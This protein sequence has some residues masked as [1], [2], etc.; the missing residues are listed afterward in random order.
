V[1]EQLKEQL[2]ESLKGNLPAYEAHRKV[3]GH[4]KPIDT[5]GSIGK[6]ARKSAVLLLVY[7]KE[8]IL[9]TVFI[10]RPSYPGVHSGQVGLPGGKV[11]PEDRNLQHT[12]LREARE[13]LNIQH[14]KLEVLGS[15]SPLYVPPSNFLIHPYLAFQ[16]SRPDFIPDKREVA[17]ILECPL[18]QLMGE[19]KLV[20][21]KVNVNG[22]PMAVRGYQLQ[23]TIIW[24]ATGMIIKEFSEVLAQTTISSEL[25]YNREGKDQ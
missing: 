7:P 22:N 12:A 4:R 19:E 20:S 8:E 13:E 17:S 14:E 21:T 2:R 18:I 24:G 10:L 1:F 3:M 11:E 9:H 23:D 16:K 6:K 5:L 15:L 25:L